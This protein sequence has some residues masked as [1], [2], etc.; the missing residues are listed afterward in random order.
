MWLIVANIAFAV[1]IALLIWRQTRALDREATAKEHNDAS[2][3][4]SARRSDFA[5]QDCPDD[6]YR[7]ELPEADALASG[8]ADERAEDLMLR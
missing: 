2:A 4:C 6:T 8:K 1:V 3:G 5:S 7:S